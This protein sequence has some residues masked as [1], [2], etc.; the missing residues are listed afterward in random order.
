MGIFTPKAYR[1]R[2]HERDLTDE[3]RVLVEAD[4]D[5]VSGYGFDKSSQRERGFRVVVK[6]PGGEGH[7][8]V[9]H[10]SYRSE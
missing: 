1:C 10:G 5:P 6:C 7:D 4:E 2:E 8:L 9:F 3:V